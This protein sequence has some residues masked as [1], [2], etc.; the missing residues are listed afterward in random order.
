MARTADVLV[1]C[2]P[3]AS[4][5]SKDAHGLVSGSTCCCCSCYLILPALGQWLTCLRWA[6]LVMMIWSGVGWVLDIHFRGSYMQ[7][8]DFGLQGV[9]DVS[10]LYPYQ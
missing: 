1:E 3:L 6:L 5:Y 7:E 10:A 8:R 4:G 9:R 2:R